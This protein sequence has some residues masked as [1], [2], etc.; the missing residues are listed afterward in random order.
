[1]FEELVFEVLRIDAAAASAAVELACNAFG[2]SN[3]A[4]NG[5]DARRFAVV[6]ECEVVGV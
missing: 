5:Y 6:G 2:V 1:M 3:R 4:V